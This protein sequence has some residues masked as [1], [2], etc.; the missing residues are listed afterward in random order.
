MNI[1]CDYY[2]ILVLKFASMISIN[3]KGNLLSRL[4]VG[5]CG[6]LIL[7]KAHCSGRISAF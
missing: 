3:E 7:L 1:F 5:S 2:C 6:N 4:V